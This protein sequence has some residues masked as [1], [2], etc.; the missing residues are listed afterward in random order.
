MRV[1]IDIGHPAH[2]HFFKNFVSNLKNDGHHVQITSRDKEVSLALLKAYGLQYELRGEMQNGMF[3]KALGMLNVDLKLY[4]IA[5]KFQPDILLGVGNPYV[6]HVASFLRKPAIIFTDTENVRTSNYLTYPFASTII[7]PEYFQ[8]RLDPKKQVKIRGFKE[9]AYLHPRYFT[10]DPGVLS[11]AGLSLNDRLIILRFISW[12]ATHDT[13]LQGIT[14]EKVGSFIHDLSRYGRVLITSES[15]IEGI[16]EDCRISV[17]PEKMHSL[18]SFACLY[19]GEGGT[20]AAEAAVLGIPSIHIEAT[21]DG[22][23]SGELSGN[24][25]ELRDRYQLMYFYATPQEALKKAQEILEDDTSREVWAIRQKR[26]FENV[27]DVTSWL[28]DFVE[29]YPERLKKSL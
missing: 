23:A 10:P 16:P 13:H 24:F 25:R 29:R 7:T 8:E 12:G 6:T 5:K 17:P 21:S 18:L 19:I 9:I 2:V 28:T 14:R 26:L 20:M 3:K 22:K 15:P 11:E 27:I 1:L 4:R